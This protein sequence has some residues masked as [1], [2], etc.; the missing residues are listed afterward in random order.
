MHVT[1]P[2][3]S[4]QLTHDN[5][6]IKQQQTIYLRPD[7]NYRVLGGGRISHDPHKQ[8][9]VVYGFS[10][11][12]PWPDGVTRHDDACQLLRPVFPGYTV[13]ASDAGY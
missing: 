10:Y 5:T 9:I 3:P 6:N 1:F 2:V 4:N 11:G 12:F 13:E 7:L 8:H